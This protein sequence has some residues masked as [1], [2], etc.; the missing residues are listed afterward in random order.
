MKISDKNYSLPTIEALV[1]VR[2]FETG[3][4]Q[5]MVIQGVCRATGVKSEFVVKYR[6]APRWF[7]IFS[8]IY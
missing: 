5:P 3:A 6:G 2:S 7:Q 1:G 8:R 4:N